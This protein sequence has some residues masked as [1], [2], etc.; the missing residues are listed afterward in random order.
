MYLNSDAA[1]AVVTV[2]SQQIAAFADKHAIAIEADQCDE[3]AESLVHVYQAF[4]TGL[5]HGSQAARTRVD[6]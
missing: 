2:A 3:L 4:F 6:P 5:A 1:K